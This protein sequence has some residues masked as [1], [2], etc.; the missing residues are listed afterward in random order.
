MWLGE[1][2]Y[3]SLLGPKGLSPN[4]KLKPVIKANVSMISNK[5]Y[6]IKK[7]GKLSRCD[8]PLN[9]IT[10][11]S[12][13]SF[14]THPQLPSLRQSLYKTLFLYQDQLLQITFPPFLLE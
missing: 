5:E 14:V 4:N 9:I 7:V 12:L 1:N 2:W 13:D 6:L 11:G 8:T 10:T 3:W